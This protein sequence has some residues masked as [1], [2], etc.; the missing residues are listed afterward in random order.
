MTI[1]AA[2]CQICP[3]FRQKYGHYLSNHHMAVE[4]SP[5]HW[6]LWVLNALAYLRHNRSAKGYVRD[7]VTFGQSIANF[8]LE[9]MG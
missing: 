5:A 1:E 4:R 6:L 7:K 9:V 3:V 8:N 2:T